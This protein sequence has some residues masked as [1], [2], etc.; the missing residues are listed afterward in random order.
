MAQPLHTEIINEIGTQTLAKFGL[1]IFNLNTIDAYEA[2]VTG[3]NSI[4]DT[5]DRHKKNDKYFGQTFED[6]E[7][8]EKNIFSS[9]HSNGERT[10]TTDQ[11]A[12][13]KKVKN[14]ISSGKKTKNLNADDRSKYDFVLKNFSSELKNLPTEILDSLGVKNDPNTDTVTLNSDGNVIAKSQHKV[15]IKTE[16]LLLDKYLDNNDVITVPSDDYEIHKS[17]LEKI[18][19]DANKPE[20][21][22]KAKKALTMLKKSVSV[23]R[24]DA[25][26]P[27]ATATATQAKMATGHIVQAGLSDAII[28]ALSSLANGAIFEIKDSFHNDTPI[29]ARIERL[30][31]KMLDDFQKTFK[32]GASYG[33][34]EIGIGLLEQIFN[35]IFT[36]IK[37]LFK[38]GKEAFKSIYNAIYSYMNGEISSFQ[39][40]ITTILKSV[41]SAAI[42]VGTVAIETQLEVFLAPILTPTV[43]PYVA[44]ALSI[45]IGSIAVVMSMKF[46]DS[47]LST[48]FSILTHR[49][50]AKASAEKVHQL[51]EDILPSLIDDEV[52]LKILIDKQHKNQQAIMSKSFTQLKK[53]IQQSDTD[54]I[55]DSLIT[56]N[57]SFKSKLQFSTYNEFDLFMLDDSTHLKF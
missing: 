7:I 10:Y 15:I 6:I 23:S 54:K 43:A 24:F 19:S 56:L 48:L 28:V 31:K 16:N 21:A 11:L 2:S 9:L 41:I 30:L 17:K 53:S 37:T 13:I 4:F 55:I 49:D 42:V 39:A 29:K 33:A 20:N 44:G 5:Y 52:R 8:T 38:K 32:R 27:R 40:L 35:S 12:D 26:N 45:I 34:L 50:L 3:S 18:A 22:K 36:K 46:I 47:V 51:C 14:I 57:S 1:N 25:K